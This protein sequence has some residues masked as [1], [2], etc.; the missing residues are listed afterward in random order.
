MKF[1]LLMTGILSSICIPMASSQTF[2]SEIVAYKLDG[3]AIVYGSIVYKISAEKIEN[4]Q[5]MEGHELECSPKVTSSGIEIA[6]YSGIC[7]LLV[8]IAGMMYGLTIGF[9]SI[10]KLII[11]SID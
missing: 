10:G 8:L 1:L 4:I 3:A 7:L 9:F 6:L 11:C 5:V 2:A